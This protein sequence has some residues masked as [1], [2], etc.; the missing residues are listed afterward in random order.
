MNR[1]GA[2]AALKFA[3]FMA[4][5]VSLEGNEKSDRNTSGLSARS[6]S[7]SLVL[8]STLDGQLSALDTQENG[9]LLWSLPAFHGPLLS[10]SLSSVQMAK[11][12]GL[13]PSLDGGLYQVNGD[14][15]EPIPFSADTLL[16]SFFK[17]PDG[18][19]LVGGKE[20]TT[21]GLNPYSG[22]LRYICS[23]DG[24]QLTEPDE[25]HVQDSDVLVLKRTQQTI[26][27]VDQRTGVERW[28]FSVGQ[29]DLSFLEAVLEENGNGR[30]TIEEDMV[31]T[32]WSLRVSI[33]NG[34]VAAVNTH[35]ASE[36]E[37]VLWSHQFDSPIAAVWRL[38]EGLV[39]PVSLLTKDVMPELTH[40]STQE[41]F[42]QGPVMYIG[43]HKG[44][45]YIQTS[46]PLNPAQENVAA[47][48][49]DISG[50]AVAQRPRQVT[51]RPYLTSSPSRTPTVVT[52]DLAVWNPM[53]YPFDNGYY[54]YGEVM[55]VIPPHNKDKQVLPVDSEDV[56]IGDKNNASRTIVDKAESPIWWHGVVLVTVAVAVVVQFMIHF[57]RKQDKR[58]PEAIMQY[59]RIP[60]NTLT[61]TA[62]TASLETIKEPSTPTT[63]DSLSL[64][65][66]FVSRYLTDFEHEL[67]LG[68][69]GF[70]LVFQAKNKVDDC[71]YAIKRIRL[72][73]CDEAL[74]KVKR[75]VKALAKLEHPGIVRYYNS[76]F[77]APPVGWQ[78][79][80]DAKMYEQ[81]SFCGLPSEVPS[82]GSG[83]VMNAPPTDR[84][85][86]LNGLEQEKFGKRRKKSSSSR[87]RH[88]SRNS[89]LGEDCERINGEIIDIHQLENEA[90]LDGHE[91]S[92][93][94]SI[95]FA[96]SSNKGLKLPKNGFYVNNVEDSA[97]NSVIFRHSDS[98]ESKDVSISNIGSLSL[99]TNTDKSRSR[100]SGSSDELCLTSS[101]H[102]LLSREKHKCQ[103]KNCNADK[104]SAPLYLFIQMQLCQ[105]ESLKDWLKTN[106]ER[107][108]VLCL[109]V[110]EEILCAVEYFHGRGLMHRDLKPSNIFFSLDGSVKVGDFG[111]VTAH[112]SENNI[113]TPIKGSLTDDKTHTSQVG[114]QLY[115][116]PE[117]MEGKAY[118]HKVD[119]FSL[120]LIF[121]EMFCP[122]GTQ[123]ERIKVMCDV[124][125]RIIPSYFEAK[126]PL[127]SELVRW[128]LSATPKA[129][130]NATEL[131]NSGLLKNIKE[132]VSENFTHKR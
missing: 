100:E 42:P 62:S 64:S 57:F 127:Q 77:E 117:Q 28:N 115:M 111:L 132:K 118:S 27:A 71:K 73:N 43:K 45:V 96:S 31:F 75:E 106:H 2:S 59:Q 91:I 98:S 14:K 20:A 67:C 112:T 84:L 4:A 19:I 120:G 114:T 53:D 29:H 79:E 8:V 56:L 23:A 33:P 36:T 101:H 102:S 128:L 55:P 81:G 12:V 3:A 124:K 119:I 30:C 69:G 47:R 54:L 66:S 110:F 22:K 35:G 85:N 72:P 49:S 95:E 74:E 38:N 61:A 11:H 32:E 34:V 68:K 26:R 50:N 87:S 52:K 78:D 63:P 46:E 116:S 40:S 24:C 123:M 129:R 125:Q 105:R 51:W 39:Q 93:S 48:I 65:N 76:W 83:I 44:Q 90:F 37:V 18:S 13:I 104:L 103:N 113:D 92:D 82:F 130:P 122:F 94:F 80:L 5:L 60:S 15:V 21:C 9:K 107:N 6:S 1:L 16:G 41:A 70:G 88:S 99:S 97:S 131:K 7:C 89:N 10:S 121:F 109:T 126:M 25:H 108:H 86:K 58:N 17:L